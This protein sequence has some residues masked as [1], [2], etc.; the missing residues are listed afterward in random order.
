M[1]MVDIFIKSTTN[2][3]MPQTISITTQT[4]TAKNVNCCN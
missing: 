3:Q 1:T 2:N 4:G